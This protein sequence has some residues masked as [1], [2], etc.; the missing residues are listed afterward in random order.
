MSYISERRQEEKDRRRIEILDA[1]EALYAEVGWNAVTM[2]QIARRARLSRALLYVYFRDKADVHLALVERGLD[3]LRIR[4]EEAKQGKATGIEEL[5]A[6]GRA[7]VKF[8]HEAPHH[9]D[10][11]SRYQAQHAEQGTVEPNEQAC[12]DAGHRVHE[13]LVASLNTG[14]ADGSVRPDLG[15]PQVTALALWAFTHG[16]IQIAA[17]KGVQIEAEGV[18]LQ[19]FIDHSLALVLN[20]LRR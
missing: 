20:S 17:S 13:A 7:Y 9:Y 15:D 16:V 11:C 12:R 4:F 14:I 18:P 2:D 6:I 10:A 5:E 19:V 8:S 3:A 1:A